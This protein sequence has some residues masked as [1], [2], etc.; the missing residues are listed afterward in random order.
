MW[1]AIK[2]ERPEPAWDSLVIA[3]ASALATSRVMESQDAVTQYVAR[4]SAIE[5]VAFPHQLFSS[6]GMVVRERRCSI[7]SGDYD[8]CEHIAGVS[9]MGKFCCT[10]IEEAE[11]QEVSIVECP[12]DKRCRILTA[13]NG[14][15]DQLG[16]AWHPPP[17]MPSRP[18]I[19]PE[20]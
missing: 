13:A 3:Q 9:Y 8:D 20:D 16:G 19:R 15:M 11:L 6:V 10:I 17:V 1:I 5:A 4:L 2:E 18:Q 12:S 7:C 14:S